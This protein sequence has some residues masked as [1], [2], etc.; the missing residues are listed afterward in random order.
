MEND[1]I[2][3][4]VEKAITQVCST[5]KQSPTPFFTESDL[6]CYCYA[7]V[8]KKHLEELGISRQLDKDGRIHFLMHCEY[9]TPFRCDMSNGGCVKKGENDRKANGKKYIRGH[10]DLIVFNPEFIRQNSYPELKA[11]NY[12]A[13]LSKILA[14]LRAEA[15]Q[16]DLR[17]GVHVQP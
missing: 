1:Q 11:Q 12:A 3:D 7:S 9:P 13:Y 16:G 14:T 17:P 5:F 2:V 8:G 15:P 4:A 10:Y 6:V